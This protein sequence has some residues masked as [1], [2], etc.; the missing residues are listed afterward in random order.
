[1]CIGFGAQSCA[2]LSA[3]MTMNSIKL[4]AGNSHPVLA[5]LIAQRLGRPLALVDITTLPNGES[6]ATISE[7][8]RDEDV[9]IIQSGSGEV[10]DHLVELLVLINACK[11]ATARR[12]TAGI[13]VLINLLYFI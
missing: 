7:S 3:A 1:M 9:Y 8:L 6:C 11:T 2:F 12:I 5:Q 4:I 13:L 10:N